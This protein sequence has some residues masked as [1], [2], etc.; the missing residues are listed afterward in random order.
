M[1]SY[2]KYELTKTLSYDKKIK[3]RKS[4]I[5]SDNNQLVKAKLEELGY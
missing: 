5:I 1:F 2:N 4:L 3:N